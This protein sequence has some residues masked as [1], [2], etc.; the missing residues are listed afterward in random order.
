METCFQASPEPRSPDASSGSKP[1]PPGIVAELRR[2][3]GRAGRGVRRYLANE[4]GDF[5]PPEARRGII[6]GPVMQSLQTRRVFA[7]ILGLG[8]F[9][10]AAR[11]VTD[12]DVWWHLRTGQLMVHT[13]AIFHS[14]PYSF[15]RFG[16]PWV[17]HEWLSQVLIF[18]LYRL[19][20]WGGLI[21]GFGVVIAAA[22]LVVFSRCPGRPYVAGVITLLG[23]FASAPSWGVRPQM[24]TFLLASVLLLILERSYQ[25]P[26]LLWWTPLLM[27]LWV[28]LHAGYALGIALIALFFVGDA[29]DAAL[30]FK[31]GPPA[32]ARLRALGLAIVVCAAVVPLNP[33]GAAMYAYPLETLRSRAMQSYIG[34]WLSP[35]FHQ[36]R[37][38]PILAMIFATVAL[39]ALSPRRLRPREILLLTVTTFAALRSVRHIPI[40]ALIAIPILST[41]ALAWLRELGVAHWLEV[42][43]P[44]MTPAK[45][46]FNALLLAG[47]L[48]FMVVRVGYVSR[49]QAETEAKEFPAAA[50]SFIAAQRPPAP[51]LNHYNWGGY[52]IWRLY[53]DYRVYI[54]GRAD[55]Y[56]DAFMDD[57]ATTYY[58]RGDSWGDPF[59]KWGIRTVVLPPDAPL[60]TALVASYGWK[61][62]YADSQAV[63]LT[64]KTK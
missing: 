3:H 13:H 46:S 38:L 56:G 43:P 2:S 60:M 28:N 19:A 36:S 40:Y 59:E 41:L 21:A 35:D 48:V 6:F 18:G 47:F 55:L 57:L 7:A 24:L 4:R 44:R 10:M 1:G 30:G 64:R 14:D 45:T 12:P 22:F 39:P 33:Y 61:T 8:L 5:I 50:V 11:N 51:I 37:Y 54:D 62:I 63:V 17:D 53:P 31:D 34:E 16:Q 26:N 15:T 32:A 23:A 25:R 52:F 20:G 9:T 27:L 58:L 29:L 49:H 42:K